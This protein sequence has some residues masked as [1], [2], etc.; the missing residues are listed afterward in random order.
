[1]FGENIWAGILTT[2]TPETFVFILV[3]TMWGIIAGA[4]PGISASMG[5]ALVLPFVIGV[6]PTHAFALLVSTYVGAEYGGGIPA[7]LIGTPGTAAGAPT[8]L[9]GHT[10]H[11]NGHGGKALGYS[12][13]A[14]TFGSLFG[15]IVCISVMP[16]L[17]KFALLFNAADFF[18]LSLF[19]LS[20]VVSMSRGSF[21]KGFISVCF[22]LLLGTVGSDL[23]TGVQRFTFHMPELMG[24]L[25]QV[26]CV[27]A[28]VA[29]G[30]IVSRIIRQ[31]QS[32]KI[33]S[34]QFSTANMSF[35]TFKEMLATWRVAL[36]GSIVGVLIGVM[37]GAGTT[38]A[39]FISYN[40]ARRVSKD[41][42]RFGQGVPDGIVAPESAN[43]ACV[44]AAMVPLLAFGI[45]GSSSAAIMLGAM[46]M[47]GIRPGPLFMT[48]APNI[49][50]SFFLA[51]ILSA[52]ALFVVGR[53][54]MKPIL[55]ITYV[56]DPH[57]YTCVVSLIVAGML[58]LNEGMFPVYLFLVFTVIGYLM[59]VAGF[60]SI[61]VVLGFVLSQLIENNFRRAL[62]I[63]KGDISVFFNSPIAV[64]F[65]VLTVLAVYFGMRGQKKRKDKEPVA[66]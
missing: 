14:G 3:G 57:L 4:L 27:I 35:V 9:D 26:P 51:I 52:V 12:L 64:T 32:K 17:A 43:N 48:T 13:C 49:L 62:L 11:V 15:S 10:M 41:S 19:G 53:I 36:F 65:F 8:V 66:I 40:E 23:M 44:P 45:P 7:I 33:E 29:G 2:F 31:I 38:I 39:S 60:H 61:G 59:K 56:K 20:A 30:E 28:L 58:S 5:M 42:H 21:L 55:Y 18:A 34:P 1:M 6:E 63:S 46:I 16:I 54:L 47:H 50:Y 37:P 24:G 22:G 25:N